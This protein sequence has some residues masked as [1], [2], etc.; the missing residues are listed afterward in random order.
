[1]SLAKAC[2]IAGSS[3]LNEAVRFSGR[4]GLQLN[5]AAFGNEIPRPTARGDL[6]HEIVIGPCG[7]HI[8]DV[9]ICHIAVE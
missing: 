2:R 9:E 4:I 7:I 6:P 1:M 8:G 3:I 5:V